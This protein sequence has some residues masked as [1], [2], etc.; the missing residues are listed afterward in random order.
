VRAAVDGGRE[1]APAEQ[2]VRSFLEVLPFMAVTA[3][4]CL[5]WDQVRQALQRPS[6]RQWRLRARHRRLPAGYLAAVAAGII[7]LVAIPYAEELWRCARAARR[8]SG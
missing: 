4:L 7:G 6:A 2:H 5:H 1:V 3:L 8:R